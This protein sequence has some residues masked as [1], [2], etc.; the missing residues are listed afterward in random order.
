MAGKKQARWQ[1]L[2]HSDEPLLEHMVGA[3]SVQTKGPIPEFLAKKAAERAPKTHEW[4]RD[5]LMQLWTFL[6]PHGLTRVADFSEH[7]VN[8]F[9]AHLCVR[10]GPQR[11]RSR[12][13]CGRSRPLPAGWPTKAGPTATP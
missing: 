10:A 7:A 6:E 13:A 12:T 2:D 1:D 3:R 4:Y 8:L 5:S 11:I 9:R